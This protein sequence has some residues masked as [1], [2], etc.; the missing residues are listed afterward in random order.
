MEHLRV[1]N[2]LLRPL[3]VAALTILFLSGC[4]LSHHAYLV[5]APS[6]NLTNG[7]HA[8]TASADGVM[9]TVVPDDWNGRPRDL[10][11]DV[12]PMKVR[13][14]NNSR[15]PLRLAYEDF[16][17][18]APTGQTYAALPPSQIGRQQYGA[19]VS[20]TGPHVVE[21]AWPIAARQDN[22]HD[23][24]RGTRIIIT[25]GF[26]WD[27]FYFAPYWGYG[28][29]GIGVWPYWWGPNTGYYNL[30]Y[31]YMQSFHLP[32]RSMLRKG[33]PEGVIAPGGYVDG[34]LYFSKVNPKVSNVEF[35]AKLQQAKTGNQFGEIEIP[36]QVETRPN[37]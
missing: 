11:R 18:E 19:N 10:Y 37:Y 32:T 29:S 14:Q 2:A 33:L 26:D 21:T 30:Y 17:I 5:P 31:P 24:D 7:G 36:F 25:P 13:I 28:Y 12:T 6:A 4:A 8:A 3:G 27:D 23:V 9:I 16:Q 35:V 20:P 22:D 34:F 15:N 1:K